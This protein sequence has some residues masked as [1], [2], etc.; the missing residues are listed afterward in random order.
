[1]KYSI[2]QKLENYRIALEGGMNHPIIS[3]R[4]AVLGYDKKKV[5]E[6]IGLHNEVIQLESLKNERYGNQR[7][8]HDTLKAD[9][10]AAWQLYIKHVTFARLAFKGNKAVWQKLQLSGKRK[11]TLAG[12][13]A[14]SRIFY[15]EI[16]HVTET[17]ATVGITAE[18]LQ[19][20][21][22]MIEAVA[23]ARTQYQQ[24]AGEAQWATQ[25][26]NQ[27]LRE[28]EVWMQRYL[29]VARL[30]LEEDDQ[31]LEVLGIVVK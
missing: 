27:S 9:R 16:T 28:L 11:S 26:R 13:L 20:A 30:A 2:E 18:E 17:M 19:Q 6:G 10:E 23:Q 1:M 14:Q 24:E 12:W 25:K 15:Q 5:R 22:A 3:Q 8:S 7:G 31:L 29:K 4:V 21:W